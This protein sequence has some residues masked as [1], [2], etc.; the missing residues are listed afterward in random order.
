MRLKVLALGGNPWISP[1]RPSHETPGAIPTL[2]GNTRR[3]VS[4]TVVHFA[5]PPLTELCL[6]S[7]LAP[8][9]PQPP[10]RQHPPAG[11]SQTPS[12]PSTTSPSSST[13]P[14]EP[15]SPPPPARPLTCLEACYELPL[16]EDLGITPAVFDTLRACVPGAVS[17]PAQD[18]LPT[19]IHKGDA[20]RDVHTRARASSHDSDHGHDDDDDVFNSH[21]PGPGA[22]RQSDAPDEELT[23]ISICPSPRHRN[24]DGSWRG[25]R[26]PVYVHHAEERWTWEEVVAGVRVGADGV[27]GFGV[28]MRWRG[29]SRGCLA[30]L[31]PPSAADLGSEP[32][33]GLGVAAA[34]AAGAP[35]VDSGEAQ[36]DDMNA[37]EET[38]DLGFGLDG[39]ADM[40]VEMEDLGL[41]GPLAD[42]AD[43]Y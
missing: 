23:G 11:S 31:D 5:I 17:R 13:D 16:T 35:G 19:K 24:P 9:N 29:C 26:V 3:A 14:I 40:D 2:S 18:P 4:A 7:L 1:P 25:G 34:S 36:T 41:G 22:T 33:S 43:F 37:G 27:A 8:Y 38:L 21:P 39:G 30:F 12:A 28:P 32:Q 42:P 15:A 6:R 20:R 10:S